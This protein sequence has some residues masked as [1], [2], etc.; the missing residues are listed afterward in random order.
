MTID[1]LLD[2][3]RE[4]GVVLQPVGDRI[5]YRA[6]T[7]ALTP[8]LRQLLA[9]HK[10]AVLLRLGQDA[11][12]PLDEHPVGGCPGQGRAD[13]RAGAALPDDLAVWPGEWR[14]SFEE[15]AAIMEHDGGLTRSQA[16]SRAEELV[17]EAHRR[18]Q[19]S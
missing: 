9:A 14:T 15:R 1:G 7:G 2:T 8:A 16:E 11:P 5:H 18:Q 19:V 13:S 12:G 10:A 17:R 3:L 6:P 4:R